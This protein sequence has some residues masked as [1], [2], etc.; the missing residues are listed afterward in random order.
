MFF[1]TG[2]RAIDVTHNNRFKHT[3]V[4]LPL[5]LQLLLLSQHLNLKATRNQLVIA[6]SC[7]KYPPK[8]L[9]AQRVAASPPTIV[10]ETP[11]RG[12]FKDLMISITNKEQKPA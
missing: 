12:S 8:R 9:P 10:V 3:V 5:L 11:D 6:H 1:Q 2:V 4:P 7:R